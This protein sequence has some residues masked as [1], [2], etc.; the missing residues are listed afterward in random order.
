MHQQLFVILL[1]LT[2][3]VGAVSVVRRLKLPSM[4]AYLAIGIVMGPHGLALMAESAEVES[5]AEFGVVFL[6]FSIGLEFSLKHLKAMRSLVFGFGFS[7]MALTALG[8]GLVTCLSRLWDLYCVSTTTLRY[9]EFTTL[10][11]AKS[12]S[13]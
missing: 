9:P 13:R 5:F 3:A 8:T 2:A 6:M 12:M 11:R 7:Q 4:L 1:L 10:D